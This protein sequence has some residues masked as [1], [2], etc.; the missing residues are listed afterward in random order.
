MNPSRFFIY[1]PVATSLLMVA[2]SL[3]GI[4]G[5]RLLPVAALP[6]IEYPTIRVSTFYPGASPE[7][8]TSL[9]TAPL[10]KQFGQMTGLAQMTSTSSSGASLIHLKFSLE[11]NL[12][13]A[14]QEVQAAINSASSYLPKS[15]PN[16][17][18]YNKINPADP[19]ILT[20][21]LTSKILP[22]SK[23]EDFAEA[24]FLQKLSQLMAWD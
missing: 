11:T 10:E 18:I 3:V 22:L 20:L 12:D 7:V 8:M 21:A 17:P 6:E 1:H 4:L 24:R 2:L 9:V 16:P 15:L 13:I 14:E 19:P 23:V 5:Y